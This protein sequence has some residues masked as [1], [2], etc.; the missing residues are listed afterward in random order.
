VP[1]SD[2]HTRLPGFE[3]LQSEHI[4]I[5]HRPDLPRQRVEWVQAT[6]KRINP[7]SK[8]SRLLSEGA[9][10]L[11]CAVVTGAQLLDGSLE[12]FDVRVGVP[13]ACLERA[14]SASSPPSI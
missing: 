11:Y 5:R 10:L 12:A 14:V 13:E 2:H 9:C 4:R 3:L 7:L 8:S 6:L 1:V